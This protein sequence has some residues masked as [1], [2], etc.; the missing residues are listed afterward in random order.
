[1]AWKMAFALLLGLTAGY[2]SLNIPPA[3]L[4][5]AVRSLCLP[6]FLETTAITSN[7][8]RNSGLARAA[9]CI[10]VLAAVHHSSILRVTSV[11]IIT[12]FVEPFMGVFTAFVKALRRDLSGTLSWVPRP[13]LFAE[14]KNRG[15]LK[16]FIDFSFNTSKS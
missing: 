2:M 9:G 6:Y 5:P 11:A 15:H 3:L 7:S 1:M 16:R 12:I 10:K 8:T 4:R 13:K 14:F